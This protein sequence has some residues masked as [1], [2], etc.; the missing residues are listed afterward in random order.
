M[1]PLFALPFAC[2]LNEDDHHF[3]ETGKKKDYL[4]LYSESLLSPFVHSHI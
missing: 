2:I 1:I 3:K 4:G